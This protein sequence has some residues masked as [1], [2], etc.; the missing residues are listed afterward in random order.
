MVSDLAGWVPLLRELSRRSGSR[1]LRHPV[2]PVAVGR[3]PGGGS[4][5]PRS[6]VATVCTAGGAGTESGP[7]TSRSSGHCDA[8]FA[9][10]CGTSSPRNFAERGEV[11]A[12]VCVV[13][14]RRPPWSTW[15]AGGPTRRARRPGEHDTLVDFYSVGKAFV[16][17]LA[18]QLVDDGLVGLDDPIADRL[19]R[20]RRGGKEGGDAPPRAVPPGRGAGHPRAAHRRRPVGL[21]THGRRTG[22]DRPVVGARDAA[23][24]PHQHVRPSDRRGR[25]A[26]QRR[27]PAGAGWRRVAGPARR[28]RARR[29]PA[30]GAA[31]L[32]RRA[33]RRVGRRPATLDS[34]TRSRA[35]R[36]M[37]MLSYFNPPGYSSMGVV[38]TPQWRGAEVPS[39]NGHGTARGV[40]RLYAALLEPGRLLSP[41]LLA[42]ATSPQSEGYCPILARGRDVRSRASSRRC[43]GARSGPTRGASATSAPG[44]AV[45]FADPDAR[46]G[47]RL[48]H[49]PRHPPL[50]EHAQPVAHRRALRVAVSRWTGGQAPAAAR[51]RCRREPLWRAG[52]RRHQISPRR[53][54]CSNVR[55]GRPSATDGDKGAP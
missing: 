39:T 27:A 55:A 42:E 46:R 43:R 14:R 32:R 33:L 41:D 54:P 53:C 18:L 6:R 3:H 2:R 20:V 23:R 50:A 36:R 48:R 13:R 30:G 7:W 44:G 8:R 22:R 47:V 51:H 25:A 12:A 28:R 17:L 34:R 40:A 49:E 37:E 35:T 1:G 24:L 4:G 10:P 9:G 21:A 29:R 19:A 15:S 45:G 52:V 16:A 31:P 38:N 26:G 5:E 11:G